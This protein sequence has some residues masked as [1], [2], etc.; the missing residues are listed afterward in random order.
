MLIEAQKI[1]PQ[2]FMVEIPVREYSALYETI[3]FATGALMGLKFSAEP[4]M[5]QRIDEVLAK[6][7]MRTP[8][9]KVHV[10]NIPAPPHLEL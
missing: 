1:E 4:G 8:S 10:V 7:R 2:P 5:A 3:C 6:V 9:F